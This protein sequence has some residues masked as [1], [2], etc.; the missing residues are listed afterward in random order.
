MRQKI[1]S[2]PFATQKSRQWER[3]LVLTYGSMK[4]KHCL[5]KLLFQKTFKLCHFTYLEA[6]LHILQFFCTIEDRRP[7]KQGWVSLIFAF[8]SLSLKTNTIYPLRDMIRYL[9]FPFLGMMARVIVKNVNECVSNN[10]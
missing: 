3:K 6:R 10:K 8:L 1:L 5:V 2:H 4:Y 9:I 7:I